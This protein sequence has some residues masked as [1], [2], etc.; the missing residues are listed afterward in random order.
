MGEPNVLLDRKY[1]LS[2]KLLAYETKFNW[3]NLYYRNCM[4]YIWKNN[5]FSKIIVLFWP[6]NYGKVNPREDKICKLL[7]FL[8]FSM[9]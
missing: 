4:R 8:I 2:R 7:S 1:V 3:F 6:V 5:M 9:N